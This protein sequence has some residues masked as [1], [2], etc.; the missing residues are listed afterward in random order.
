MILRGSDGFIVRLVDFFWEQASVC[1]AGD[2]AAYLRNGSYG[3]DVVV[4]A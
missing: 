2:S 4:V 1:A 3:D